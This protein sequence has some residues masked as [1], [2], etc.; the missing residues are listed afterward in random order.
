MQAYQLPFD[1]DP[2]FRYFFQEPGT[3]KKYQ[4]ELKGLGTG[5]IID[6]DGYILTNN[7]VVGNATDIEALLSNGNRYKA[8]LVGADPKTDLAVIKIE[9]KEKLPHITFGDSDSMDVGNWVVAIGHPR[10]LDQTVTQGIISAKHRRG[11]TDPNSYQDFL[12]TDAAINPG[13]SGGPL[14]NLKGEVIGVNSIIV[15]QSG[16]FEGIGFAIPSN[17][18]RF[19]ASELITNGKVERGWLG[20]SVQ[21]LTPDLA[22]SFGLKSTTGALIADVTEDGPAEVAGLKRGDVVIEFNGKEIDNADMLKNEVAAIPD[23]KTV[24]VLIIRKGEKKTLSVKIGNM[25]SLTKMLSKSVRT[26][27]GVDVRPLN[28]KEV[29]VYNLNQGVAINWL[30]PNGPLGEAGFE[31]GDIIIEAD[32]RSIEDVTAFS[33]IVGGLQPN[34]QLLILALDHRTGRTAY[35]QVIA[36]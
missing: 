6:S 3:S 11:I 22:G 30:D 34:Q 21:D 24:D 19:I 26:R 31:V 36:R 7:H 18:A 2:F 27:L 16:G 10:G 29:Q 1:N 17:M 23:G 25:E 32:G 33:D 28:S 13:N 8:K 20:V 9:A 35:V 14:L 5:M 12:Q 15:S 4:R